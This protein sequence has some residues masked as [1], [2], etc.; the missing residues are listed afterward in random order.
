MVLHVLAQLFVVYLLHFNFGS[1]V[2]RFV[3]ERKKR[4]EVEVG[5]GKE[6]GKK[7]GKVTSSGST[8]SRAKS[9]DED[10]GGFGRSD[11]ERP[12]VRRSGTSGG[13]SD[14]EDDNETAAPVRMKSREASAPAM[15]ESP[16]S[17]PVST[18]APAG[19]KRGDWSE[20][21]EGDDVYWVN[22]R[23]QEISWSPPG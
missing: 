9:P 11:V 16:V 22:S 8:R 4:K 13:D 14:I 6:K 2:V 12:Q 23:T 20:L 3:D 7:G 17:R 1:F 19:K 15:A 5:K 10:D 18:S 21:R